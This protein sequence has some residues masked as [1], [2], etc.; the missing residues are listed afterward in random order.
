MYDGSVQHF[1]E[2]VQ[3]LCDHLLATMPKD[4]GPDH[5][6]LN[7]LREDAAD[8]SVALPSIATKGVLHG[9]AEVLK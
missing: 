5:D 4:G 8:I 9:I 3:R 1:A 2:R 6:A 7:R